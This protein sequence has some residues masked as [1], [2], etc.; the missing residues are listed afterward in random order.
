MKKMVAIAGWAAL[1][2]TAIAE[3]APEPER[4]FPDFLP[5]GT[6]TLGVN[7]WASHAAVEMWR[8]WDAAEIEKDFIALREYGLTTLRVFPNWRDFQPI[9][10]VHSNEAG[11]D[12]PRET[13]VA[14]T[15]VPRDDTP[16]GFAGVDPVMMDRFDAFCDLAEK[17]GL[18]FIV[19]IMTGQMTSRLFVPPALERM[20][21]YSDP[22]AL[23]WEGRFYEYFVRRFR[24]RRCIVAWETGNETRILSTIENEAEAEAWLRY[25]HSIIRLNDPTR[26][27]VGPDG[28]HILDRH[29]WSIDAI[30]SQSDVMTVHPYYFDT[31]YG[32]KGGYEYMSRIPAECRAVADLSG[33]PAFVEEHNVRRSNMGAGRR[34]EDYCRAQLWN[35][36]AMD[37]RG[38]LWWCAFD[39]TGTYMS[40][41]N[42]YFPCQELGAF[43]RDRRPV[44]NAVAS[45]RFAAF[46]GSLG[47]RSL[48]A[49]KPDAVFFVSEKT[50]APAYAAARKA[51][52]LPRFQSPEHPVPAADCYFFPNCLERGGMPH[53][54]WDVL[55]EK[56]SNGATLYLSWNTT[57]ITE[58]EEVFGVRPEILRPRDGTAEIDFG[59]FRLSI[60]R[61]DEMVL[62]PTTAEVL[63]CD[64]DG[65]P[66]FFRHRYGKGVAYL[67]SCA[68]EAQAGHELYAGELS[69]LYARI[70]PVKRLVSVAQPTVSISDHFVSDGKAYVVAVNNDLVPFDGPVSVADGWS[71][72]GFRTDRP[73]LVR[74]EDGHLRMA[75]D[76]GVLFECEKL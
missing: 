10:E 22:Y 41:Y 76:T 8:Q 72:T 21:L 67:L 25:T 29:P 50:L 49:A 61:R 19:C 16:E 15:A 34:L 6:M 58:I 70:C 39:Q 30:A 4:S 64:A 42:N 53:H 51:G 54:R 35:L 75:P 71:I 74:F 2:I 47:F 7:Y 36:W 1:A 43:T 60:P 5:S 69:R 73:D 23:K 27:V 17:H 32:E 18:R 68:P 12:K 40:P 55:K 56:V 48:P 63:A 14:T 65:T 33:R 3:R 26:P 37:C 24:G 45:K 44:G 52:I 59:D 11:Y 57:Y 20:N 62:T 31:A 66:V 9:V 13:H 38:L 46:L 28:V